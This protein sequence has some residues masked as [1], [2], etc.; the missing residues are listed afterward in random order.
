MVITVVSFLHTADWQIGMKASQVPTVAETVRKARLTAAEQ[1]MRIASQREVDFVLIAG[2]LFE[3]NLVH[4][5]AAHRVTEALSACSPI[6]V[7]VLP[8]NHDPLTEDSIYNRS[9]FKDYLPPNVHILR[10]FEPVAPVPGV[11]LLPAP[12]MSKESFDDPTTQFRIPPEMGEDS[13]IIGI[14]HGSLRIPGKFQENDFPIA[15]DAAKRLG[16]DYLAL[17]HWH[18]FYV[19]DDERTVYAGT[20]EPTGFDEQR[21]GTV[22]HVTIE[23]RGSLPKIERLDTGTLSWQ[24]LKCDV[25]GDPAHVVSHIKH[26]VSKVEN[27]SST[28]LRLELKGH[29]QSDDLQW[30]EDLE[31]WLKIRLLY[32]EIDKTQFVTRPIG[33]RLS[34]L[35][36][37]NPFLQSII[38]DL[39]DIAYALGRPIEDLPEDLANILG[40]DSQIIDDRLQDDLDRWGIQSED[41][42]EAL[43]T[44]AS[45]AEE[46][47]S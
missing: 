25:S 8:G 32:I 33:K 40:S 42:E 12:V 26:E 22:A 7:Y 2:D 38:S 1:L 39:V 37:G 21:K 16:L 4:N 20:H 3:N 30:L 46:V 43:R 24:T 31:D 41:V 17:G 29:A 18:S 5:E 36:A 6:P 14:A 9:A 19:H 28:L 27:P 44:L 13:I 23:A 11:M 35:A 10:T 47:L 15:L 34:K 45:I